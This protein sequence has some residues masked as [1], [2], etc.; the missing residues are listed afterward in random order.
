[1]YKKSVKIGKGGIFLTYLGGIINNKFKFK[2]ELA[3]TVV[4][5]GSHIE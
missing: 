5:I 1:M 3:R 4:F 2:D